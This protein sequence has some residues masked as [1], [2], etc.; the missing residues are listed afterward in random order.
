MAR[1]RVVVVCGG[2]VV[3][4]VVAGGAVVV[5]VGVD[6]ATV[7][8]TGGAAVEVVVDVAGVVV[9]PGGVV[10]ELVDAGAAVDVVVEG[11]PMATGVSTTRSRIPATAADAINKESAVAPS[12]ARPMPK[13]LLI[14]PSIH[15]PATSWVK[16]RLNDDETTVIHCT[17]GG[18]GCNF[19]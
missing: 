8:V 4:V 5:V 17:S 19:L 14:H 15:H 13:Y 6:A 18:Y 16:R 12:H 1:T 2:A 3:V 9:G 10:V 11:R 7:V